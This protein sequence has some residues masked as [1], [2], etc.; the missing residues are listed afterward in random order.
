MQ[1]KS[2]V[3][4]LI[5]DFLL[6][7]KLSWL[8]QFKSEE[9][10]QDASVEVRLVTGRRL[11]IGKWGQYTDVTVTKPDGLLDLQVMI[12]FNLLQFISVIKFS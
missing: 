10:K 2:L 11:A 6:Y 1:T 4:N 3:P 7:Y 12:I 8:K 5:Q 9:L